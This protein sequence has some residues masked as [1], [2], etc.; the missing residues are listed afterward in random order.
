M[1]NAFWTDRCSSVMR[2]PGPLFG[3]PP[4]WGGVKLTGVT[5]PTLGA[6]RAGARWLPPRPQILCFSASVWVDSEAVGTPPLQKASQVTLPS[7]W[8]PDFDACSHMHGHSSFAVLHGACPHAQGVL[9]GQRP[10]LSSKSHSILEGA[11]HI[12]AEGSWG[13]GQEERFAGISRATEA[14]LVTDNQ[15]SERRGRSPSRAPSLMP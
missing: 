6:R 15:R 5:P 13:G 12:C 2:R 3:E 1:P 11:L 4:H 14:A 8:T 7:A 10:K 9:W